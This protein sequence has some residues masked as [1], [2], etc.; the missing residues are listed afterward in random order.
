MRC[1]LARAAPKHFYFPLVRQIDL[2]LENRLGSV[3]FS[4][5]QPIRRPVYSRSPL[6]GI[7]Q[8]CIAVHR[9][10]RET[11]T[12]NN[13]P[14]LPPESACRCCLSC[15]SAW[16]PRNATSQRIMKL[17]PS[18]LLIHASDFQFTLCRLHA[19]VN[20]YLSVFTDILVKLEISGFHDLDSWVYDVSNRN[21]IPSVSPALQLASSGIR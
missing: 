9:V 11:R 8:R 5:Q 4:L 2:S 10:A 6:R 14:L 18:G 17:R 7:G 13:R 15:L 16:T 19:C 1:H 12:R 3:D 20:A 21:Y